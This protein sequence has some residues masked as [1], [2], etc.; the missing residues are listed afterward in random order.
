MR[1]RLSDGAPVQVCSRAKVDFGGE[2]YFLG[3]ETGELT[4]HSSP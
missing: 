3:V 1:G 4:G 2:G